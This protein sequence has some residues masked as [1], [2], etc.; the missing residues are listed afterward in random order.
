MPQSRLQSNRSTGGNTGGAEVTSSTPSASVDN[1]LIAGVL[2]GR[3]PVDGTAAQWFALGVTLQR[4]MK[5]S[6][7]AELQAM[8]GAGADGSFGPGTERVVKAWQRANGFA[9]TGAVDS[10]QWT[11]LKATAKT[12]ALP[13][14]DEAFS[15]MWEAHPHNYLADSSLGENTTSSDLQLEL[16]FKEN[17]FENTCA[18]RLSTM[19]NRM[20]G[21]FTI[22][23]EKAKAA[24]LDKM[25]SSG[26]YLP[27][28]ADPKTAV[29]D[30]RY[31]VSAKEMWT[32]LQHHMGPPTKTF[33]PNGRNIMKTDGDAAAAEA[34]EY[35]A[36]KKG[37]ICFD[38]LQL[39]D[40][41]GQW[42]G[43]GGSGHVDIFDGQNLSDGSFYPA[44]RILIW[45]VA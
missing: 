2:S 30:D 31:I 11:K 24:G 12:F 18:L 41:S 13:Q 8:V 5:G 34:Q 10:S 4:G 36:G 9:E 16:G 1:S 43:Y 38:N 14:G 7:I 45:K 35:C 33:P 22:T 27:R 26:L 25:R 6:V 23:K 17:T 29:T 21:Q 44:Q 37:F 42:S 40:S 20:G 3:T 32:Y 28:G 19:L 39:K 15:K